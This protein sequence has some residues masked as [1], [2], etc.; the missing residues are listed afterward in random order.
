[1]IINEIVHT[2]SY[3]MRKKCRSCNLVENGML[4]RYA[5]NLGR[6]AYSKLLFEVKISVWSIEPYCKQTKPQSY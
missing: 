6:T 3:D 1:M 4:K 2:D 5:N